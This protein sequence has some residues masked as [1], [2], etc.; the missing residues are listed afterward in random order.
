MFWKQV[1]CKEKLYRPDIQFITTTK[2]TTP[3]FHQNNN[4]QNSKA[5][6]NGNISFQISITTFSLYFTSQYLK[7][8]QADIRYLLL[9]CVTYLKRYSHQLQIHLSID[10][11]L[12]WMGCWYLWYNLVTLNHLKTVFLKEENNIFVFVCMQLIFYT[13]NSIQFN[14][15]PSILSYIQTYLSTRTI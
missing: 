14:L 10:H 12:H 5:S 9:W 7:L 15:F 3:S 13:Y 6:S 4:N 11:H 8:N 1:I 2:F